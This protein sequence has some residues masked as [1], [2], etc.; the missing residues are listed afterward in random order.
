MKNLNIQLN[1]LPLEKTD[2]DFIVFRKQFNENDSKISSPFNECLKLSLPISNNAE[3]R[4]SYWISFKEIEGF[5]QFNCYSNYNVYVTINYLLYKLK[6]S[7]KNINLNTIDCSE[8]FRKTLDFVI[9]EDKDGKQIITLEPYY[10]KKTNEFGILID[11]RFRK[12][13]NIPF[14]KSVQRKSLSLDNFYKSNKNYYSEKNAIIKNFI[15]QNLKSL[16][17][18][19]NLDICL[20][21]KSLESENLDKTQYIFGSNNKN[22]SQFKGITEYGPY[23]TLRNN[24]ILFVFVF[25]SKDIN[26]ARTLYKSIKGL[27]YP[28][29]FKGIDNIFRIDFGVSNVKHYELSEFTQS[30]IDNLSNYIKTELLLPDTIIFPIVLLPEVYDNNVY[31]YAKKQLIKEG[32]AFQCVKSEKIKN[33]E[34]FKWSVA[35]ISLQIFA[36]LGG[37]PWIVN[38]INNENCLIMGIGRAYSKT[39]QGIDKIYTYSVCSDSSGYYYGL[40][41]L[42]K[43][44]DNNYLQDL[45]ENL[46]AVFDEFIKKDTTVREKL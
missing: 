28:T 14:S 33:E 9:K 39:E 16:F 8:H 11:Y 18:N 42:S 2:F 46:K 3:E 22:A 20:N 25:I 6:D 21:L 26:L 29:L 41:Q 27:Q 36:K 5:E 30:N 1:F 38:S 31:F 43:H 10:L 23:K 37:T 19:V 44:E 35:N 17:S 12:D 34:N 13:P 7:S 40:Y 45:K 4:E 15:R 24:N 32:I